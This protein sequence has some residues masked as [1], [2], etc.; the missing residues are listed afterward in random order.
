MADAIAINKADGD[1]LKAA[2]Q[3]KVEF[4]RALHLYPMKDSE[5]Q[6]KVKLCSALQNTG[7]D[8]IWQ[9]IQ[10]YIEHTTANGYLNHKRHEQ[11]KYWLLQTIEEQLKYNFYNHPKIK[12]EL[13]RQLQL[14]E[15]DKTTPFA[16]AEHLLKLTKS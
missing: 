12:K 2:K 1:N 4:N 7:I 16:A 11:N 13:E 9:L 10:N 6:P 3:A 5:W 15:A 8:E 14:I